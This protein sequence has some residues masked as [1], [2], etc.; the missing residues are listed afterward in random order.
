MFSHASLLT[1]EVPCFRV[2][3]DPSSRAP[4]E[5]RIRGRRSLQGTRQSRRFWA[6]LSTAIYLRILAVNGT[7]GEFTRRNLS[8]LILPQQKKLRNLGCLC[9][10]RSCIVRGINALIT[11]SPREGKDFQAFCSAHCEDDP[12]LHCWQRRT[13]T[14]A[15]SGCRSHFLGRLKRRTEQSKCRRWPRS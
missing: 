4:P 12:E 8:L 13:L 2:G 6:L 3:G 7:R 10:W 14:V 11:G 5:L 9:A 15:F 1:E